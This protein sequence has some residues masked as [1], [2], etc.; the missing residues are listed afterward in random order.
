MLFY[1]V[2]AETYFR[3]TTPTT[4]EPYEAGLMCSLNDLIHGR[5]YTIRQLWKLSASTVAT[6]PSANTARELC[7]W[8]VVTPDPTL[9]LLVH[10]RGCLL[11]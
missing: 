5:L 1:F 2:R 7:R 6:P 4:K 3:L 8:Y 10:R 9:Q 11:D